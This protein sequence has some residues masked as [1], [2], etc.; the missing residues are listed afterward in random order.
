MN[1]KLIA[2]AISGALVLPVAALAQDDEAKE[3]MEV[4]EHSHPSALE[5]EH[6][7]DEGEGMMAVPMHG[8]QYQSHPAAAHEHDA[9]H[10][11]S[12]AVYG[13]FRYGVTMSDSDVA[14]SSSMWDI[15]NSP[16]QPIRHQGHDIGRRRVDGRVPDREKPR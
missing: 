16:W 2:A 8:H 4:P 6:E 10:G 13:T 9:L 5:H 14:G 1:R 15:G 11:H 7:L 12:S 3:M